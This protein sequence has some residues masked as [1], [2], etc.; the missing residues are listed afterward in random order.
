[1][2]ADKEAQAFLGKIKT[3]K[4]VTGTVQNRVEL[5]LEE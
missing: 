1:M 4:E 2:Q 5:Y 3:L